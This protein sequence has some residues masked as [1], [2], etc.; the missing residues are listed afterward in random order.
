MITTIF[1]ANAVEGVW[2]RYGC[3][4]IVLELSQ[5]IQSELNHYE[6]VE[7]NDDMIC[8]PAFL[9][10]SSHLKKTCCIFQIMCVRQTSCEEGYQDCKVIDRIILSALKIS[11]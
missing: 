5:M 10:G 7:R 4:S 8:D 9:S 3:V 2:L 6:W 11:R 1:Y